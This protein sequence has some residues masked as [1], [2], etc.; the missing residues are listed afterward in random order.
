MTKQ[1]SPDAQSVLNAAMQHSGSAF[2]PVVCKIVASAIR[3]IASENYSY[4]AYGEGWFELVVDVADLYSIA[5]ELEALSN[6]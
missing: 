1:L 2:E 3:A 4:E 5:N 6:D